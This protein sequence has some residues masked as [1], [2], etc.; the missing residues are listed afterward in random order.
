MLQVILN[1]ETN[2][3]KQKYFPINKIHNYYNI[4]KITFKETQQQ[5]LSCFLH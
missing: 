4:P 1:F 2:L 3:Q 5:N